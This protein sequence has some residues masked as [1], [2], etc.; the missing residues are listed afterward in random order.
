MPGSQSYMEYKKENDAN[1]PWHVY[2][3]CLQGMEMPWDNVTCICF[4]HC[5]LITQCILISQRVYEMYS[6]YSCFIAEECTQDR[7]GRY[8]C[9]HGGKCLPSDQ[10]AICLCPLGFGGDL[11]E[12]RLDLQVNIIAI[13]WIWIFVLIY[14][15]SI[16]TCIVIELLPRFH[17]LMVLRIF[18]S[19]RSAIVRWFG[20][21]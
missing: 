5:Y 6:I 2:T 4:L 7:C 10:G 9:R 14:F 20:S 8:P 11:C 15:I 19:R 17:R 1:Q 21:S 18:V 3:G 16:N 12:M 13:L